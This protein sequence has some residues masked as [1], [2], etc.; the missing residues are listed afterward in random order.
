MCSLWLGICILF[1]LVGVGVGFV[2]RDE[3]EEGA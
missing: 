1:L 3:D 2:I